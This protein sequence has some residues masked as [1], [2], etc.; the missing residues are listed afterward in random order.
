MRKMWKLVPAILMSMGLGALALTNAGCGNGKFAGPPGGSSSGQVGVDPLF[1][2]TVFTFAP[3]NPGVTGFHD[4]FWYID[5]G[6]DSD[7]QASGQSTYYADTIQSLQTAGFPGWIIGGND[8]TNV[9]VNFCWPIM[10]SFMSQWFRRNADGS[11]IREHD[12]FGNLIWSPKSLDIC[13]VTAPVQRFLVVVQGGTIVVYQVNR[14]IYPAGV[15]LQSVLFGYTSPP[16]NSPGAFPSPQSR[17]LGRNYSE[18]GVVQLTKLLP[19]GAPQLTQARGIAIDDTSGSPTKQGNENVE[20]MGAVPRQQGGGF[21]S[22][23]TPTGCFG[24]LYAIDYKA[25]P[26]VHPNT[27]GRTIEEA[28]IEYAR[29]FGALHANLISHGIGLISNEAGSITDSKQFTLLNGYPYSFVQKDLDKMDKQLLP[30]SGRD[31][32]IP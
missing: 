4:D 7:D 10:L 16:A 26:V 21:T 12:Q 24:D 17:Y 32:S 30:G 6:R 8:P 3:E 23:P 29:H 14:Q 22:V 5:P 2:A 11:R 25:G 19:A 28:V 31:P 15:S 18:V 9:E 1:G 27:P 20:N 13:L